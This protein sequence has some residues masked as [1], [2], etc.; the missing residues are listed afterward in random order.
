MNNHSIFL[1][2]PY[3]APPSYFAMPFYDAL[4][5]TLQRVS[6]MLVITRPFMNQPVDNVPSTR[7]ELRRQQILD[8]ATDCFR[9]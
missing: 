6:A 5:K 3:A 2:Y 9:R 7:S 1:Q 8:A 4:H